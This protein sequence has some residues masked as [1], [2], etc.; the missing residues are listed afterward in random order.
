[1]RKILFVEDNAS[2]GATLH[3]RLK[4]EGYESIWVQTIQEARLKL[5]S[6]FHLVILDV[7]L[8]D[9][10]GF[11]LAKEIRNKSGVPFLFVTAQG[12]PEDRLTGYEI[13]AEE[14]ILKPFHLKEFLIRV[15]RVLEKTGA[16]QVGV[17][18]TKT[19][20]AGRVIDWASRS[21]TSISGHVEYLPLRDYQLL[22]LFI[23]KAPQVV[24][25]DEIL[26]TLWP[27]EE[28]NHHLR[29]ID[30]VVVRLRQALSD[31]EGALIRSVRGVGYQ[32]IG[33]LDNSN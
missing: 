23:E 4:K 15:K 11:D 30:N 8:P 13:G 31:Q 32:W 7:G 22:K 25:R 19:H 33:P 21:I 2:L 10:S 12:S 9:G 26:K 18:A 28:A 6:S 14:Y 24:S 5:D 17:V 1:M 20:V 16:P 29:T 27:D 3:E